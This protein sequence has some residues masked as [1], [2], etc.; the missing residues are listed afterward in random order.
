MDQGLHSE[1]IVRHLTRLQV[2]SLDVVNEDRCLGKSKDDRRKLDVFLLLEVLRSGHGPFK[3]D[4]REEVGPK[5]GVA[6]LGLVGETWWEDG[7]QNRVDA[8]FLGIYHLWNAEQTY[9][10]VLEAPID[11]VIRVEMLRLAIPLNILVGF[12]LFHNFVVETHTGLPFFALIV[13]S[14]K[15]VASLCDFLIVFIDCLLPV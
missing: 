5:H 6:R 2:K 3:V 12:E 7:G 14:G 11:G 9:N 13:G 8:W 15:I 4:L 1:S 10:I